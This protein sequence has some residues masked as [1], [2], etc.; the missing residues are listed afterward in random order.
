MC[1]SLDINPENQG[2]DNMKDLFVY[3][4]I[5][6]ELRNDCQFFGGCK[7]YLKNGQQ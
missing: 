2:N 1:N 4:R 6:D 5:A 3:N 7:V